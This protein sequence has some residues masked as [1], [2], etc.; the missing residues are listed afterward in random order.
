[1]ASSGEMEPLAGQV[2][3]KVTGKSFIISEMVRHPVTVGVKVKIK[4]FH[5]QKGGRRLMRVSLKD[6]SGVRPPPVCG[7]SPSGQLITHGG[8][9]GPG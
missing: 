7:G 1:M 8:V 2:S 6:T 5:F 4:P 3:V 9:P